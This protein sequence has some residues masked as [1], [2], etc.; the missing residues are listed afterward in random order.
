MDTNIQITEIFSNSMFERGSRMGRDGHHVF[1][2]LKPCHPEKL[3]VIKRLFATRDD[4]PLYWIEC[5]PAAPSMGESEVETK[6]IEDITE[7]L[8]WENI[9]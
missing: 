4:K 9:K 6:V 3:I 8:L 5:M 7:G 1:P 2:I